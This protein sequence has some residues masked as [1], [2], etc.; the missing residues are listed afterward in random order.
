MSV[1]ETHLSWALGWFKAKIAQNSILD[2]Y[3]DQEATVRNRHETT[4][5]LQIGK[6]VW[7]GCILSACLFNLYKEYI[8]QNARLGKAQARIKIA[9]RNINNFR[10]RWHHPNGRNWRGTKEPLDEGERGEWKAG[11]KLNIRKTNHGI[12]SHHFMANRWGNNGNSDKLYFLGLQNH[13]RWWL[14]P[15]N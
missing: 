5:W 1:W 9:V 6:V 4:D 12:Q 15:W 13:C 7:Q 11:L 2:L 8:M 14:Q 10:H 3:A